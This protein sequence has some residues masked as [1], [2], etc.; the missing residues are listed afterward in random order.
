VSATS[1]ARHD[2][3]DTSPTILV[4]VD[5]RLVEQLL[6]GA[7]TE[8]ETQA[9]EFADSWERR[10]WIAGRL[11]SQLEHAFASAGHAS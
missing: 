3:S 1:I 6:P 5:R 9:Q 8:A 7:I 11:G 2:A 4:S 10:S